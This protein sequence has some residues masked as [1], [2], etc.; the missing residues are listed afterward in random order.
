M[1]SGE[2]DSDSRFRGFDS[3]YF[4][5]VGSMGTSYKFTDLDHSSNESITIG[6]L[7]KNS[8]R[9]SEP[10][11]GVVSW[12]GIPPN[13]KLILNVIRDPNHP[14]EIR[15]HGPVGTIVKRAIPIPSDG[16]ITFEWSG[17]EILGGAGYNDTG[18]FMALENM[19]FG[20][21]AIEAVLYA[22]DIDRLL[23][24]EYCAVPD[25]SDLKIVGHATTPS[26]VIDA[27]VDLYSLGMDMSG[28]TGLW[29]RIHHPDQDRNFLNLPPTRNLFSNSFET[30]E[31]GILVKPPHIIHDA[32]S[33]SISIPIPSS[34]PRQMTIKLDDSVVI[35][36]FG[37][38]VLPD[39]YLNRSF[40]ASRNSNPNPEDQVALP[41]S[42]QIEDR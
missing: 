23:S 30:V 35:D 29:M 4:R 11:N 38:I 39:Y 42:I 5:D 26:F 15:Y 32:G 7:A 6:G 37:Q 18:R 8:Y 40:I 33:Y 21:Y 9:H 3:Q 24:A 14:P 10:I 19:L 17:K 27:P 13:T 1:N 34:E 31:G 36:D 16:A 22:G 2:T 28:L 41:V 20:R 25:T 12:R